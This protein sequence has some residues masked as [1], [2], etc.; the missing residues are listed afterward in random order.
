M[1]AAR[2]SGRR[3]NGLADTAIRIGQLRRGRR[4]QRPGVRRFPRC[5]AGRMRPCG[6]AGRR[7]TLCTGPQRRTHRVRWLEWAAAAIPL[8]PAVQAADNVLVQASPAT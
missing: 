7:S 3:R 1:P 4:G 8:L 2:P 5:R 6:A